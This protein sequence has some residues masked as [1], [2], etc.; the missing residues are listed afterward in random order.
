M[1]RII[2]ILVAFLFWSANLQAIELVEVKE[3]TPFDSGLKHPNT[4]GKDQAG[5]MPW[6]VR[7]RTAINN[8]IH[9]VYVF[10]DQGAINRLWLEEMILY[11]RNSAGV[12]FVYDQ[13]PVWSSCAFEIT[14]DIY[15]AHSLINLNDPRFAGFTIGDRMEFRWYVRFRDELC[16]HL[17]Q[18]N[19]FFQVIL[20]EQLPLY[21]NQFSSNTHAHSF[22]TDSV[23]EWGGSWGLI[24]SASK[25]VD[26]DIYWWTDHGYE[27]SD[28]ECGFMAER[29]AD[30]SDSELLVIAGSEG[31][32]DDNTV[33]NAVDNEIHHI[34]NR[35]LRTPSQIASENQ[36]FQLWTHQQFADSVSARGGVRIASH[37]FSPTFVPQN[38]QVVQWNSTNI[39]LALSDQDFLG[40]QVLNKLTTT[41]DLVVNQDNINPYPYWIADL[42]IFGRHD[43]NMARLDLVQQQNLNPFRRVNAYAG[44]DNHGAYSYTLEYNQALQI[45]ANNN[46]LGKLFTVVEMPH[47]TEEDYLNALG[48]GQCYISNGPGCR[49]GVDQDGNGTLETTFG[50]TNSVLDGGVIRLFGQSNGEFGEFTQAM[51]YHLTETSRDST[52][53]TLNGNT[54]ALTIPVNSI[55]VAPCVIRVKLTTAGG[56]G[57]Y[58]G[59]IYTGN[60]YFNVGSAVAVPEDDLDS[61]VWFRLSPS[62]TSSVVQMTWATSLALSEISIVD[63]AGRT[64]WNT[65]P[66]AGQ[67]TVTWCGTAPDG[68]KVPSGVYFAVARSTNGSYL[69]RKLV[70]IK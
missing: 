22:F 34:T 9:T 24:P 40:F 46:A 12:W 38:D 59:L 62:V 18:K 66:S 21:S 33:N 37:P 57:D 2:L 55:G 7:D 70:V 19:Q 44:T 4:S 17:V 47:L 30:M 53:Y 51:V 50:S 15:E 67:T 43:L 16:L 42:T 10:K 60:L 1:K 36:S 31:S 3:Y 69:I 35:C 29:A 54:T 13:T 26:L 41:G 45:V 52:V 11:A 8:I 14:D 61:G 58:T 68:R 6:I 39:D 20:G 56:Y 28:F 63:V 25:A 64:I 49:F 32:T 48:F 65:S 5:D 23:G 27:F